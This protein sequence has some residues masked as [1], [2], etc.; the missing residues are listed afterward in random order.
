MCMS[1]SWFTFWNSWFICLFRDLPFGTY[2]RVVLVLF[3]YRVEST[4]QY[5]SPRVYGFAK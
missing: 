4:C 3:F 5:M 2:Y 1:L